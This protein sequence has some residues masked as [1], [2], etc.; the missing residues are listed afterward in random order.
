MSMAVQ[1]VQMSFPTI[2]RETVDPPPSP[3]DQKWSWENQEK[4]T[5]TSGKELWTSTSVAHPYVEFPHASGSQ[6][7]SFGQ[8]T[9]MYKTVSLSTVKRVL[10]HHELKGYSR[11][12]MPLL[13]N[14]PKKT[15]Y[16]SLQ[17][18]MGQMGAKILISG[19]MSWSD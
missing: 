3:G 17:L 7:N 8:C 18:H 19:D 16:Y 12:R 15:P 14:Q 2:G 10:Y 5:K 4:S 13:Q 11:M 1:G 6:V 9:T